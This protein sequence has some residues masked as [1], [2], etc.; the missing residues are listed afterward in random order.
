MLQNGRLPPQTTLL[1]STSL[2]KGLCSDTLAQIIEPVTFA[3]TKVLSTKVA[4][5]L[6][7]A[8][9]MH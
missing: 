4:K 1:T 6:L 8:M 5:F 2:F 7:S 9:L 3:K